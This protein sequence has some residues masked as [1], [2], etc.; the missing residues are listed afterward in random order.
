MF[1]VWF[2]AY[3]ADIF[4]AGVSVVSGFAF[5]ANRTD[6]TGAVV[7]PMSDFGSR[8]GVFAFAFVANGNFDWFDR[9]RE[10]GRFRFRVGG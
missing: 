6:S 1:R 2:V 4:G 5:I 8:D 9:F 7:S 10:D 3:Y